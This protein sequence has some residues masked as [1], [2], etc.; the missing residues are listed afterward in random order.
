[1]LNNACYDVDEM[2][3]HAKFHQGPEPVESVHSY[4]R[5]RLDGY[6]QLVVISVE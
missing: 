5:R 2:V 3:V 4:T 6:L 1:M